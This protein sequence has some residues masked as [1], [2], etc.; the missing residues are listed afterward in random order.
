MWLNA[1]WSRINDVIRW[2][3]NVY[4]GDVFAD[5]NKNVHSNG[6]LDIGH[7][8]FSNQIVLAIKYASNDVIYKYMCVYNWI[9]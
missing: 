6:K 5:A 4:N 1:Q 2:K 7:W 9:A 8:T 3:L